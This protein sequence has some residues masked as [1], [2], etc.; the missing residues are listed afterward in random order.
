MA[1]SKGLQCEYCFV[2]VEG[3]DDFGRV[4]MSGYLLSNVQVVF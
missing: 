4:N 3:G 2:I 1:A